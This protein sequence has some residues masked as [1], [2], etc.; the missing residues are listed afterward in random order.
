MILFIQGQSDQAHFIE[1]CLSAIGAEH[2]VIQTE[3][4]ADL[5]L[6]EY[7]LVIIDL[8]LSGGAGFELCRLLRTQYP[9][10]PLFAVAA[11]HCETDRILALELGADDVVGLPCHE[12]EFQARVKARLRTGN[13]ESLLNNTEEPARLHCGALMLDTSFHEAVIGGQ[14]LDLT[15]TEF[16]LLTHFVRHPNQVFT[17][18]QLLEAVWGYQYAGYEHTVVSH[19]NRLRTKLALNEQVASMLETVRGVGYRLVSQRRVSAPSATSG[20]RS[21]FPERQISLQ[22]P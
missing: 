9:S 10:L 8:Q 3:G 1:A 15:A 17:R 2:T 7:R 13:Q 4:L 16:A 22:H 19:I 5:N 11:A 21:R 6:S 18:V 20:T 14:Q 12:R